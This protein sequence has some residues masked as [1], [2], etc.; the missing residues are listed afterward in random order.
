MM[1]MSFYWGERVILLFWEWKTTNG[2]NYFGS[3]LV[4]FVAAF[5]NNYLDRLTSSSSPLL[6]RFYKPS[7]A[8]TSEVKSAG[9]IPEESGSSQQR[10]S[11]AARLLL[12]SLFFVR[13]TVAYLLM[14]AIMSYNGG[15]FIAI[16]VGYSLG[17]YVFRTDIHGRK[18]DSLKAHADADICC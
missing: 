8:V 1:Q 10:P 16:V 14:L 15:V 7:G 6:S 11:M 18:K 9:K 3:L 12:T 17:F 2:G 13:V 5:F 4:L